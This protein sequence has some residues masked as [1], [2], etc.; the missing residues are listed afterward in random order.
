MIVKKELLDFKNRLVEKEICLE[1]SDELISY[2]AINGYN[3]EYGA[4]P[5]KR[6]IEKKLEPLLLTKLLKIILRSRAVFFGYK[7]E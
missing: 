7:R 6:L 1:F 3:H 5:L 4:R 2:F